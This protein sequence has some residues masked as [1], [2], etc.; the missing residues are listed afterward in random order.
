MPLSQCL[1]QPK[2]T[3]DELIDIKIK[4]QPHQNLKP[5]Y[6]YCDIDPKWEKA[7]TS[8]GYT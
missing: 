1:Y 3:F 8:R 2:I 5:S 4:K 6:N 7:K